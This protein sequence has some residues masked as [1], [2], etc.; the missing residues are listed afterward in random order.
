MAF[1]FVVI[2]FE[3]AVPVNTGVGSVFI[4]NMLIHMHFTWHG[5]WYQNVAGMEKK[6]TAHQPVSILIS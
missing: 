1:N 5:I 3:Y 6:R 4:Y 2:D